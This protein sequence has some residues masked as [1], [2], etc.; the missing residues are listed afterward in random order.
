MGLPGQKHDP[1]A[2]A[3]SLLGEPSWEGDHREPSE[4]PPDFEA[5]PTYL[6]V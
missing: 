6:A 3:L 2:A 5:F 4:C 1:C